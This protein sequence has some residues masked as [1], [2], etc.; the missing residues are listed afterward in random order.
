LNGLHTRA[1]LSKNDPDIVRDGLGQYYSLSYGRRD[2]DWDYALTTSYWRTFG[3]DIFANPPDNLF[4]GERAEA[5]VEYKDEGS[6]RAGFHP[7]AAAGITF[8]RPNDYQFKEM[9]YVDGQYTWKLDDLSRLTLRAEDTYYPEEWAQRYLPDPG[10]IVLHSINSIADLPSDILPGQYQ[11]HFDDGRPDQLSE[12]AVGSVYLDGT[13]FINMVNAISH[14][15]PLQSI[16][17]E[18]G[19]KNQF[20]S[21]AKYELSWPEHNYLLAGV[22]Y[23]FDWSDQ[24]MFRTPT[25]SDHNVAGYM[26][27]EYH[28]GESF[29]FLG[30]MRFDY[31]S[32]YASAFSPRLSAIC[33]VAP[34]LRLKALYGT[35]YRAPNAMERSVDLTYGPLTIQGNPNL[36]PETIQQAETS[37]EYELGNW[38]QAKGTFFYYQ[39]Q[40]EITYAADTRPYLV[41]DSR[42]PAL[43]YISDINRNIPGIRWSNDNSSLARGLELETKYEPL[44]FLSLSLNYSHW[45]GSTRIHTTT[46]GSA[47]G[48]HYFFNGGL[49]LHYGSLAFLNFYSSFHNFPTFASLQDMLV[50]KPVYEWI[51]LFD[52]TAGV[53]YMGWSLTAGAYNV[54][55]GRL[56]MMNYDYFMRP[57]VYRATLGYT[58]NF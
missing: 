1:T 9:V 16:I 14:T 23:L 15:L 20:T 19:S 52:V 48:Y 6:L 53:N 10:V 51:S 17:K 12:N 31:N 57:R 55:A 56:M 18:N 32:E 26:Q 54:F 50:E 34:G 27:D 4:D 28:L 25:V 13:S 35:A 45:Y 37:V 40:D 49:S 36:K 11:L 42:V 21:E 30:G 29:I 8:L 39:T 46:F 24:A 58:Y 22:D 2:G 5:A 43:V 44:D 38:L 7:G 33:T 41:Y 3:F 47:D